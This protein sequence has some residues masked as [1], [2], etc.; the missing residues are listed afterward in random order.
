[1]ESG[2]IILDHVAVEYSRSREHCSINNVASPPTVVLSISL[3]HLSVVVVH[4][5]RTPYHDTLGQDGLNTTA[6]DHARAAIR[7]A[8]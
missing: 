4:F 7:C 5:A 8:R 3:N 1:M 6:K 2:I